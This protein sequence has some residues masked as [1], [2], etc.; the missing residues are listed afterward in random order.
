M[1]APQPPGFDTLSLHAGHHPDPVTGARAVPIYQTTSYVFDDTDQAA[2]L[3]NLE[4][5]GYI[6]SR[7][8]NPTTSVLEERLAAL[9]GG[10]GAVCTASGMAAMH[11]GIATLLGAGDHIVA[12]AS[13]YGGTV[14]LLS[15]TLPRFGITTTFVKP[16]DIDGFRS[17]LRPNTRLVIGETIGNPGLEVFDIPAIAEIAHQARIPLLIDSTFATPYLCRPLDLGADL[18]MHSLTK[19]IGGHGIAIGGALIDGGR[20]DWD[21]SGKFPTLTEPVAGYHGI[22]FTEQ[23]G[24][25]AFVMRARTEGLRQ[26]GVCLSPLNAFHLLQGVET[27]SLRVQRHQEN[28]AAVLEFLQRSAAVAWV[29]H[30][31]LPSHPDHELARRLLPRGAGS[32]VSFGIKGGRAAG[33]KF[34]E[35]LRLV[36]HLANVGDAKTLVIHPAS[37]TH[38]QLSA[39]QLDAAGIGE[40]MVRLSVGIES[41]DDVIGDLSQALRAA[42]KS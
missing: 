25:T 34:I 37:T 27:L 6:Y 28:T 8:S 30:P 42:T 5:P 15:H 39:A 12:S 16:R 21:E 35:S 20:F 11:I 22:V 4:R 31:N 18:V 13:L 17:A 29:L 24:P 23:F 9:E 40:D 38:Q 32:V 1:A 19:W 3:F 26:F 2:S 14:N 7:I 36:S 10:V 41:I 33:A